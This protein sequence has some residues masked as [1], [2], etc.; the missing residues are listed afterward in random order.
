MMLNFTQHAFMFVNY[1]MVAHTPNHEPNMK[2]YGF[3]SSS[4]PDHPLPHGK[5]SG[6]LTSALPL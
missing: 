6:K 2:Q 4:L 1:S 3:H 5:V